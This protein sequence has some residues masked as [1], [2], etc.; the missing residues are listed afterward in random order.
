M[1]IKYLLPLATTLFLYSCCGDESTENPV[2]SKEEKTEATHE[3]HEHAE[4]A[5]ALILNDGEKWKINEEMMPPLT[6]IAMHI[7]DFNVANK[8][9]YSLLA[10]NLQEDINSL[11][12]SCSM[13][14]KSHD[15]LHK[16]LVPFIGS[17]N[18]LAEAKDDTVAAEKFE[19]V[20]ASMATFNEYFE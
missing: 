1:K 7:N 19:A 11:I 16:W 14:G 5:A 8:Q 3:G 13:T 9:D 17:V 18:D 15:E 20:Q 6:N 4:E 10:S 2:E 12:S